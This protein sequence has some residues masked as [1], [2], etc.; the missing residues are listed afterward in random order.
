[1]RVIKGKQIVRPHTFYNEKH[2]KA[3]TFMVLIEGNYSGSCLIIY[4]L[5]HTFVQKV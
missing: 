3:R 2:Q 1:M 5:I 4:T